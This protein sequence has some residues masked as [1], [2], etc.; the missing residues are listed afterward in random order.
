MQAITFEDESRQNLLDGA[1]ILYK[2]VKTTMGPKGRNVIVNKDGNPSITHDG[3]TVAQAIN[4]GD[5]P[6]STGAKIIKQAAEKMNNNVG[7]G[8]TTVTVLTYNILKEANKLV[9][10]GH[11]PM[12]L[13]REIEEAGESAQNT[14]DT[15]TEKLTG[16][17]LDEVATI[18]AGESEVGELVASVFRKVGVNGSVTVEVGQSKDTA[19][20]IVDGYTCNYGYT[21]PHMVTNEDKQEAV[22]D[23]PYVLLVPRTLAAIRELVPLFEKLLATQKKELLLVCESLE[24]EA[25]Q[26]IV[27]NKLKGTLNCVA[28]TV[29]PYRLDIYE[30]LA[31]VTGATVLDK[32]SGYSLETSELDV[33]GGAKK[34]VVTNNQLTII[35]G[36]GDT[37]ELLAKLDDKER[38]ARVNGEVAVIKVGGETDLEIEEKKYRVD[39]AVAATRSA[40]EG[41]IVSGGG[42]ALVITSQSITPDTTG[43]QVLIKALEQ[44]CRVL[45]ENAGMNADE[46]LP[47]IRE[48]KQGHGVNVNTGELVDLRK[49][50]VIDPAKVT[51][52]AL[53]TAISIA[54]TALTV[55]AIIP[56]LKEDKDEDN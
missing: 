7:D 34:I 39:D 35:E 3:V 31:A 44:P 33:L 29:P 50:G 17:K 36:E 2:A 28:V 42:T 11:N 19:S 16:S 48:A 13:R 15:I 14:L 40:L 10:A 51:K 18:S 6:R 46:W 49:A 27:F 53:K 9:V 12:V 23:S 32:S 21:S 26:N 45:L 56:E 20:Q 22:Y 41:G 54:A 1:E 8:T 4:L 24:G 52:E 25:L 43:A 47:K 55:G 38:I 30:E 37:T 5:D